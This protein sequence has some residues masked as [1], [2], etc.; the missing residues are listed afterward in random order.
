[1]QNS[2]TPATLTVEQLSI[3]MCPL[4]CLAAVGIVPCADPGLCPR[5][6]PRVGLGDLASASVPIADLVS[7]SIPS[8]DLVSTSLSFI[9]SYLQIMQQCRRG[10][11]EAYDIRNTITQHPTTA[12][13]VP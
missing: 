2:K 3:L 12:Q 1:L 7:T 4:K 10:G 9:F 5:P 8:T 11:G 13:S 6:R